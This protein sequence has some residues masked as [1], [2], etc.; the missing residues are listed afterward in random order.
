[1]PSFDG[2]MGEFKEARCQNCGTPIDAINVEFMLCER[3]RQI[4]NLLVG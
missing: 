3:C 4:P 2:R 1:M